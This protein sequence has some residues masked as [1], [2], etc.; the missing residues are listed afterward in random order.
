MFFRPEEIHNDTKKIVKYA[1]IFSIVALI[2]YILAD[3]FF[4]RWLL[5]DLQDGYFREY[6][7][8][9]DLL[10]INPVAE[11]IFR[12]LIAFGMF[13]FLRFFHKE[14]TYPFR[15]ILFIVFLYSLI[16]LLLLPFY[17]IFNISTAS[18]STY[19]LMSI[20]MG[21]IIIILL[22]VFPMLSFSIKSFLKK[23]SFFIFV[24]VFTAGCLILIDFAI[25]KLRT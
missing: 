20:I 4:N 6:G 14:R 7:V 1:I 8:F 9:F 17:I 15:N 21:F 25:V 24:F 12:T 16:D 2:S 5:V 23:V 3:F 11:I 18:Y 19:G 10:I 13:L 22:I